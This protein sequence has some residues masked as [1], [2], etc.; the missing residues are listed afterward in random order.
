[1]S[2][3]L[4]FVGYI[5]GAGSNFNFNTLLNTATPTPIEQA[6][7]RKGEE[8]GG[9]D[10]S[11]HVAYLKKRIKELEEGL[12]RLEKTE[13][14][15]V[16]K[17]AGLIPHVLNGHPGDPNGVWNAKTNTYSAWY[18]N[19]VPDSVREKW[20][21]E[22]LAY[23]FPTN[24]L[25]RR[26]RPVVGNT[27]RFHAYLRKV[28]AGV[29]TKILFA[30]GS[31]TRGHNG[32]GPENA[33]PKKFM[34][35]L[36]AKHPCEG[37]THTRVDG[38]YG[39]VDLQHLFG[40]FAIDNQPEFDLMMVEFNVN[41]AFIDAKEVMTWYIDK[42]NRLNSPEEAILWVTEAMIRRFLAIRNPDPVAII[43]FSA[44]YI[45]RHWSFP[46][47]TNIASS[48]KTLFTPG[49]HTEAVTFYML[50]L[51]EIPVISAVDWM[52][53]MAHKRGRYMMFNRTYPY[54]TAGWHGDVCCHP[55]AWG[56][57]ILS[58]VLAM[59]FEKEMELHMNQE[60]SEWEEDLT[61]LDPPQYRDP[62]KLSPEEAALYDSMTF[63][64]TCDFTTEGLDTK[65]IVSQG[66]WTHFADNKEKD[67]FGLIAL[68]SS[69][70]V[71]KVPPPSPS[72]SPPPPAVF[73]LSY[74]SQSRP[75]LRSLFSPPLLSFSCPSTRPPSIC[76]SVNF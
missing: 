43:W 63:T 58:L 40:S 55:R 50:Q 45:G 57:T 72:P 53:P 30:G 65:C 74:Y 66:E 71:V 76:P 34:E 24:S 4:G 29:C 20:A 32:G 11:K 2:M 5:T 44:D 23:I 7:F 39:G 6:L 18:A 42:T 35:W 48:R 31:V 33:Y 14:A 3:V 10:G 49:G 38:S 16:P 22:K 75:P 56:H 68:V 64:S 70:L 28:K 27:D 13:G 15:E 25:L 67:K 52:L 73:L 62:V 17:E 37:G 69:P 47:Y 46:P 19:L 54:N 41:D 21:V 60:R 9:E 36:N 12:A 1:M 51:Y 8:A 61:L 26:S 59:E